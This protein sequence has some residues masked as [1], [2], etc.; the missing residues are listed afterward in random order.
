VDERCEAQ[1]ATLEAALLRFVRDVRGTLDHD[2]SVQLR[3]D[4]GWW[5]WSA[6]TTESAFLECE[7]FDD[8]APGSGEWATVEISRQITDAAFDEVLLPW[9]NCPRHRDHPLYAEVWHGAASWVC[10]WQGREVIC[11]IGNLA[12][13]L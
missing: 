12:E 5:I 11:R 3:F 8:S 1:R 13:T 10:S 9:P 6:A 7:A 4:D 2:F